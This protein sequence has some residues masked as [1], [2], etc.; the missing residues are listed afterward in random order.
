LVPV[1]EDLLSRVPT[2]RSGQKSAFCGYLSG[3]ALECLSSEGY[4]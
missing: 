2:I 3:C 1:P 4:G